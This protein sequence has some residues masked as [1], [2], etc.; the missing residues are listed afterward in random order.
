M[1]NA[2]DV[3]ISHQLPRSHAVV[4]R[5]KNER[6]I[7]TEKNADLITW[8]SRISCHAHGPTGGDEKLSFATAC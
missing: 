3:R 4:G 1:H 8:L 6:R 5:P 2:S 7:A